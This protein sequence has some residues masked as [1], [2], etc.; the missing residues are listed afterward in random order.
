MGLVSVYALMSSSMRLTNYNKDFI[1]AS[2]LANE[3]IELVR[4]IRDGNYKRFYPWDVI[5]QDSTKLDRI[6]YSE[7]FFPETVTEF[8]VEDIDLDGIFGEWTD[9]KEISD[10][11]E[12][13]S[14]LT[15]NMQDYRLY[16]TPE[17]VYTHED[18]NSVG[19]NEE[20]KFYRYVRFEP[21]QYGT[22]PATINNALKVTS[23]VLWYDK[24]LYDFEVQ[25]IIADFK[26]L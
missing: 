18:S 25:T 24:K 7:N 2:G 13:I 26:K 19:P 3:G 23:K 15:G 5:E 4:N 22:S 9:I 16:K 14:E 21:V 8:T 1:V 20:T 11:S 12:D 6:A 10:F 17:G